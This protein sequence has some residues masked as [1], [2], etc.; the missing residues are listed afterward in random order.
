MKR[1][2]DSLRQSLSAERH[3]VQAAAPSPAQQ[4]AAEALDWPSIDDLLQDGLL[5][6]APS[7]DSASPHANPHT[8]RS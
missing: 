1:W 2:V 4:P 5:P 7:A 3:P 6:D 8:G